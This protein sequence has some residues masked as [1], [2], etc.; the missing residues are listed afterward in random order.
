M[1]EHFQ[2]PPKTSLGLWAAIH[3]LVEDEVEGAHPLPWATAHDVTVEVGQRSAADGAAH[4]AARTHGVEPR[5]VK[6]GMLVL[7]AH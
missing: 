3:L 7:H 6:C 5:D 1:A 2:G 4:G